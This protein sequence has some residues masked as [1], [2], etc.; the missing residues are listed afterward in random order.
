[1][2]PTAIPALASVLSDPPPEA[3]AVAGC[4]GDGVAGPAGSAAAAVVVVA[5]GGVEAI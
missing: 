5:G 2:Q 4:G 3:V 1:M